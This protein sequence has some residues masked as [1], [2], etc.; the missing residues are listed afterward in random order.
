MGTNAFVCARFQRRLLWLNT[1]AP[2]TTENVSNVIYVIE[3]IQQKVIWSNTND[4]FI[5]KFDT[6]VYESVVANH[7]LNVVIYVDMI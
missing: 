7:S 3:H 4:R 6:N 1:C 2:Y 5:R